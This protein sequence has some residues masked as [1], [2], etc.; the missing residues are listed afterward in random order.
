MHAPNRRTNGQRRDATQK[1][2]EMT[3]QNLIELRLNL[4]DAL[5]LDGERGL[6]LQKRVVL[7]I[8]SEE[9]GPEPDVGPVFPFEVDRH[10]FSGAHASS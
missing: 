9:Q 6:H 7:G 10:R 4:S 1:C 5:E 2:S 8:Q 3:F